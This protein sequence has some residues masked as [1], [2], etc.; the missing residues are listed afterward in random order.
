MIKRKWCRDRFCRWLRC[1]TSSWR[2]WRRRR[3]EW[4][5]E[6]ATLL[7]RSELWSTHVSLNLNYHDDPRGHWSSI[8]TMTAVLVS[9]I[10]Q[11]RRSTDPAKQC[12]RNPWGTH[13]KTGGN[14]KTQRQW[15]DFEALNGWDNRFST[16][17]CRGQASSG[18][19]PWRWRSDLLCHEIVV[20][21][22]WGHLSFK[23]GLSCEL[24]VVMIS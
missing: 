9:L 4:Y 7:M 1:R 24:V 20:E 11:N 10:W 16:P 2:G 23:E 13:C 19:L 17:E 8:R 18:F 21:L 3:R 15:N 5:Q 6:A 14:E 22:R 12:R